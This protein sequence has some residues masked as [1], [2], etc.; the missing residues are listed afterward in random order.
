MRDQKSLLFIAFF[1]V[2][3]LAQAHESTTT[4]HQSDTLTV[5]G[6]HFPQ[7]IMPV[8][9]PLKT[10]TRDDIQRRQTKSIND[11]LRLFPGMDIAQ[12][13]GMGQ[14]SSMFIRGTNS[15]HVLVLV[16]GVRLNQAG[17]TG[18]VDLN[19]FPVS[20]VQKIEYLRGPG[21]AIYGSDA[22]GGVINIITYRQNPGSTLMASAGSSRY[23]SYDGSTQQKLAHRTQ[24]TLA[25]N[26]THTKGY[27]VVANAG[28]HRQPDRDGFMSKLLWIGLE[29]QFNSQ[30]SGFAHAY[31]LNNRSEYDG[32]YDQTLA[33]LDT[34]QLYNRTYDFALRFREDV[35]I[36]Q[37]TVSYS[38]A[39]DYNYDPAYGRYH[40]MSTLDD[41][42]QYSLQWGHSWQI[43]KG[44]VNMGTDWQT[45]STDQTPGRSQ[46]MLRNTGI[47]F[48]GH[49]QIKTLT[50]E[51][52]L[53][54]DG[55]STFAR[56]STW[57]TSVGW[58]F[59][60]NYRLIAAYGTA[61]KA[62]NMMQLYSA[63]GGNINLKPE[64]SQQWEGSIEAL[65][66]LITWRL[67]V[68]RNYIDQM[69]EYNQ[70]R[71]YNLGSVEIKGAEWTG[72]FNTGLFM[73]Q[74]SLSYLDP[75]YRTSGEILLR[76]ARQQLTYQLD[77][78]NG[79]LDWSVIWH[80]IGQ[81]DDNIA[82]GR[83]KL[84]G[85]SVWDL[86]VSYPVTA[87][88]TVH[89][90]I[91]NLFDKNYETVYGYPLPGRGYYCTGSYAF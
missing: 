24:V 46:A 83:V 12:M 65:T 1:G 40:D 41:A 59:L 49:Q 85:S 73:H 42:Q 8:L 57:Q 82:G 21:L 86:A 61:F 2:A 4:A 22:V 63:Y 53:R 17:I 7:L 56:H 87:H 48:T 33:R 80:Y 6:N 45:Q 20:L 70:Y 13:G 34:R 3:F 66:E 31:A 25:A 15:N 39:K 11:I 74:V 88:L 55:G 51:G 10:V 68:Y 29:H 79:G 37:L 69:I 26:Y 50:V 67:S 16:D 19:Q 52:S 78:Q 58:E 90:K 36:S 14:Q 81:R 72:E 28:D 47:Y 27:D 54:H 5:N 77:W 91:A 44:I 18:A 89:A 75:R 9:A 64:E 71:Y 23:Q 38:H 30:I 35:Y 32:F 60:E 43:A 76:R 62:P 84:G